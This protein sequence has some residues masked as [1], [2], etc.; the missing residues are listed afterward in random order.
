M[1]RKR[2]IKAIAKPERLVAMSA[3]VEIAAAEPEVRGPRKFSVSAYTGGAMNL[4][5]WDLPVVVD[6]SGLEPGKSLVA[7]LDHKTAQR[8]GHVT[9]KTNDG[10]SLQLSG[11]VSAATAFAK[12]VV[13]SA[14]S[15]FV[16]Q[17]SIEAKPTKLVEIK[18]GKKVDINGQSFEG[19]LY[20]VKQS[21]LKGF[22]FVSHGADDNTEV[23]IA[24]Q[25]ASLKE[26]K[27]DPKIK[28]WAES[29]G[30]DVDNATEDAIATI[31]ANYAGRTTTKKKPNK[32]VDVIAAAREED[33]RREKIADICAQTIA[34]NP[35][36]DGD[37]ISKLELLTEQAIEA[38]WTPDKFDTEVLRAT[39]PQAHTVFRGRRDERVNNRV[40]E[41]A[42]CLTGNL[43]GVDKVFDDQTLQAAHDRFPNGIGLKQLFLICAEA[44]GYRGNYSSDITAEVQ[45][46]A[47]GMY[48][49]RPTDI[50]AHGWS[51]ISIATIISN[52]A[53]KY[54]RDGWNAVDNTFM[55]IATIRSVRDFKEITTVS[56]TG[57]LMFEKVGK[58][59]EI[60]HGTLGEE[61]YGN[62]ADT[63]AK[64]LAITR[65]DM[66]NDDVGA[67]T[68]V[69]RR[70]GRGSKLKLNDIGWAEFLDNSTFFT[71]GN[72]NVNTGVADMTVGGLAATEAIF[73]AMTDPDG[74]PL[75]AM[76][77]VLL[78][79]TALKAAAMT[80]MSSERLIDGTG[81]TIQGDANIWRGRFKVLSSPY[82]SNSAYTG[83]SASAYYMLGD[84]NDLPLIEIAAL[85]GRV[86]PVIE[87]ADAAFNVLGVQM[88]GYSDV[89]VRLQEPRAGVRADGGSS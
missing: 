33:D 17:A 38:G 25:A 88:R 40:I 12:E 13:E 34:D 56:L 68:N 61:T 4:E 48:S 5:G 2:M 80:L 9:G 74:K 83:Y 76:P 51:T 53:N 60:P 7:N 78:V 46:Y 26:R 22:A 62:K 41:A 6:L 23:I 77:T 10:K 50:K 75:G 71:A 64:M 47:F 35:G 54:L 31:E 20:H 82:L 65:Q 87:T 39:R 1:L 63:Y 24:A 72:G 89:G 21:T 36:R 19:P 86:E 52:T 18:A 14:D 44:N 84:K 43:T 28:A 79:P 42:L 8:V 70:L 32:A 27:M 58:G 85:N 67:L 15:G 3:P 66:I 73:E 69:P 57:D 11:V 45:N 30:V 81:T 37:F 55:E 29:M 49:P 16:W 59:G